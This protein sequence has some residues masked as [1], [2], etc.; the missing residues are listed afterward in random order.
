[1]SW[2]EGLLVGLLQG[3][4][5]F[6]PVSSSGHIELLRAI[7]GIET[8]DNLAVTVTVHAAT[9]L[10]ILTVFRRESWAIVRDTA[11]WRRRSPS[12]RWGWL[13]VL[14][15]IPVGVVGLLW[16]DRIEMFF[17]GRVAW[18][19]AMLILTGGWLWLS[20]RIQPKNRPL[21]VKG[22]LWMGIAQT[23]A[24]LPGV[25]RSGATIGTGLLTGYAKD[26]V[27]RFAFLMVL[28]PILGAMLIKGMELAANP[29]A[30]EAMKWPLA[31]AFV[32]AYLSGVWA[33]K[34]MLAVVRRSKLS[35]FAY[36][37]VAVGLVAIAFA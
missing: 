13:I 1:M 10:S 15:M 17:E 5:E 12:F 7:L 33:C 14:S 29:A 23:V 19:G 31:V 9:A 22:A 16:E 18:V 20:A 30:W 25:S 27:A 35:Y 4:T 36:Y 3:L 28:P 32:A 11:L 21:D 24:V 8:A 26:E 34:W 6:L 2:W 37:C